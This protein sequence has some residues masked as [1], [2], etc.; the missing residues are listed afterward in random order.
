[1][2]VMD[3]ALTSVVTKFSLQSSG[4]GPGNVG[5]LGSDCVAVWNDN[6]DVTLIGPYGDECKWKIG[7]VGGVKSKAFIKNFSMDVDGARWVD[8]NGGLWW[9]GRVPEVI[10][11]IYNPGSVSTASCVVNG[12]G[13]AGNVGGMD[14]ATHA[15]VM[16]AM[17]CVNG[18]ERTRLARL[19][20][21]GGEEGWVKMKLA[22]VME[23]AW[24]RGVYVTAKQAEEEDIVETLLQHSPLFGYNA[25]K[26][27]GKPVGNSVMA[28][29][30]IKM[31][32]IIEGGVKGNELVH[33]VLEMVKGYETGK[34]WKS[35]GVRGK[36]AVWLKSRGLEDEGKAIAKMEV[37]MER[38]S[39]RSTVAANGT[40]EVPSA[41]PLT[42]FIYRGSLCGNSL[43]S[44]RSRSRR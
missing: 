22:R 42:Q 24:K 1:M 18:E 19:G 40:S 30:Q 31:Q 4:R 16:E 11:D 13:T 33:R 36:I 9:I 29:L 26:L 37:R 23:S 12:T 35:E 6:G 28:L 15:T 21:G 38:T 3:H 20:K 10:E 5:W 39:Q 44:P 8:S 41:Y 7:S 27:L 2:V 14:R 25:A 43:H 17:L 32:E 34:G